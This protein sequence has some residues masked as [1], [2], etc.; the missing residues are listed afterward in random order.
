MKTIKGWLGIISIVFIYGIF[1]FLG[2]GCPIKYL[3]GI[4]CAG[5]GMTRAWISICHGQL[6]E[7]FSF[8]PLVL[9][10]ILYL[11]IYIFK[12]KM[13]K[14]LFSVITN[15]AITLFIAVYIIR[16]LDPSDSIV[17]FQPQNGAIFK[18]MKLLRSG[19]HG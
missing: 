5:C 13:N 18:I 14:H 10:P 9:V 1:S 6:R 17:V 16:M 12:N 11:A 19:F 4:S 7:A 2:M 15:I 8:H 3:T